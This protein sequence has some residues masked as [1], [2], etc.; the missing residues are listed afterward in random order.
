MFEELKVGAQLLEVVAEDLG[1]RVRG[2]ELVETVEGEGEGLMVVGG[3]AG[4]IE[5]GREG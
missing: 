4:R 3:Q 5:E 2:R 1:G